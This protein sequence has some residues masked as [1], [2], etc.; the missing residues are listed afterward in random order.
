MNEEL[1]KEVGRLLTGEEE[2]D[3]VD[4]LSLIIDS[5]FKILS[6]KRDYQYESLR[7]KDAN[8][9][10]QMGLLKMIAVHRASERFQYQN[11]YDS[12]FFLPDMRDPFSVWPIVRSQFENYCNFNHLYTF[13][14][15]EEFALIL[16]GLWAISGFKYR[17]N[18]TVSSAANLEKK[19]Q[20]RKNIETLTQ[21][22][23]DNSF[24]KQLKVEEKSKILNAIKGKDWKLSADNNKRIKFIPWQQLFVNAGCKKAMDSS[25]NYMSLNSHPTYVSVFQF[26]E[27]YKE[28]FHHSNTFFAL[29]YST[30]IGSFL[31]RDYCKTFPVAKNYF[32]AL[33]IIN[34]LVINSHNRVFRGEEYALNDIDKQY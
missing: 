18:L 2:I 9:L 29:R 7:L 30:L 8:T 10:F 17:Q 11:P 34:Q 1:E 27:I 19:E 13:Q 33:P 15:D 28:Q 6:D 32:D 16:Y 14:Q 20:E 26:S 4:C 25:Y 3:R 24:Y 22:I 5:G 21:E 23:K 31:I 12:S